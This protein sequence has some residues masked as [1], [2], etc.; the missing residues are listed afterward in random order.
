MGIKRSNGR[1]RFIVEVEQPTSQWP[2]A[3]TV[4]LCFLVH[5]VVF[6][7]DILLSSFSHIIYQTSPRQQGRG[8]AGFVCEWA[9][10]VSPL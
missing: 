7:A 5:P 8:E 2:A 9:A 1:K 6:R 3:N 4:F 10:R